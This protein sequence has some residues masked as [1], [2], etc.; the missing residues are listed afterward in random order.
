VATTTTI[1]R[2]VLCVLGTRPEVIKLAPLIAELRARAHSFELHV[3]TTGQHR[4][5]LEHALAAFG[6]VPDSNL[7]LM[8][9]G[10]TPAALLA[11]IIEALTPLIART[12]PELV[13]VQGDTTTAFAGALAAYYAQIPVAHVEAGLRSGDPLA[14]FPEEQHR[15]MIDQLAHWLFAPTETARRNLLREGHAP[16]RIHVT[17]NTGIDALR[18]LERRAAEPEVEA[19]LDALLDSVEGLERELPEAAGASGRSS[20]P[21]RKLVLAT[22]HRR[23]QIDGPLEQICEGLASIA[24]LRGVDVLMP[25]HP[26]PA[27]RAG[28]DAALADS[29]VHRIPALEPLRFVGLLRRATLVITD[30]GGVQEEAASLGIPALIVRA[31]SDRPESVEAGTSRVVGHDPGS[32]FSAATRILDR[33]G[34]P[35]LLAA[36]EVFGDGRA[37]VRIAD[38]LAIRGTPE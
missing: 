36:S 35:P 8:E 14:P 29:G 34:S 9:P 3:C 5:L 25:I 22:V 10:Q 7:D 19:Q 13:I 37:A 30:S 27:I 15:R 28:I 20:V 33:P 23:E 6:Q 4:E 32:I 21:K 1:P 12:R 18:W 31:R 16:E 24:A 38:V 17:G 26:N 11:K 2:R